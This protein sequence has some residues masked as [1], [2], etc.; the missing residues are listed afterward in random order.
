MWLNEENVAFI[1]QL[2]LH[3]KHCIIF[4]LRNINLIRSPTLLILT[5]DNVWFMIYSLVHRKC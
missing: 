2:V 5:I 3:T 4:S 1:G